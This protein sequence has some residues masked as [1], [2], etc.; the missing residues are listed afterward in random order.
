MRVFTDIVDGI[1]LPITSLASHS[2][3]NQ[4]ENLLIFVYKFCIWY[5][6]Q[7]PLLVQIV[8]L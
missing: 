3:Y 5:P 2:Y 6:C 7:T 1:I 4:Y 8:F